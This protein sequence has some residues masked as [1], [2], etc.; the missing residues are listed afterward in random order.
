MRNVFLVLAGLIVVTIVAFA[1]SPWPGAMVI[2]SVFEGNDASTLAAM[3]KHAPAGIDYIEDVPY[4]EDD[5]DAVLDVYYPKGTTESLPT[6]VWAHGGAWV[7]G[8]KGDDDPYFELLAAEGYTVVGINYTLGPEKTYPTAVHQY[9]DALAYLV[10]NADHLH[11]D[12][13]NF[14]LAGDSA[15]AQLTSQLG[16]LTTNPSY[17][18]LLDIEPALTKSQLKGVILNCGI[19]ELSDLLE[20][21]GLIG[22]GDTISLWAYTGDR[23]LA[24]SEAIHQMSSIKFVTADFPPAYISGGNGDPLTETQSKA[25]ADKLAGLGV[26]VSTLFWPKDLEPALPHEY[27][28]DLDNDEGLQALEATIAFLRK[29]FS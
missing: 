23:D 28:F 22:W 24:K 25:L 9:N 27:Q 2:R 4:R 6:V 15:G 12:P 16:V 10:A 11:I 14:V 21:S 19:Y 26:E 29:T 5:P 1:I 3:E 20:V 17:A 13:E 7:S 8:S 18:K